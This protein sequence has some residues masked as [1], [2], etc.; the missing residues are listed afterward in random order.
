MRMQETNVLVAFHG[1]GECPWPLQPL[2]SAMRHIALQPRLDRY[3]PVQIQPVHHD[4][5]G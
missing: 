4:L 5:C 3:S 2:Y 1:G